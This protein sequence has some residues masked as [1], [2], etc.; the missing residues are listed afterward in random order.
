MWCWPSSSAHPHVLD[1][2]S[3]DDALAHR[4]LDPLL[5]RGDEAAGD[6]A[7][8]DR[9]HELEPGTRLGGRDLDVAVAE[10]AAAAGLLLVAAV[11]L[12]GLSDRL[13]VRHP[14]RMQLDL[15]PEAALHP[16]DDHLDV[17]L[18]E[19]GDDLLAGL[20]IAMDVERGVLLAQAPDRARRLLLVALRLR[21]EG[22]RHHRR[23][24]LQRREAHVRRPWRPARR[25]ARVSFSLATA[26][27]SPGPSSSIGSISL[28]RGAASWPSRS[29]CTRVT[30]STCDSELQHA[31]VHAQQV[32][33]ARVGI[34]RGLEYV[35][36]QVAVRIGLDLDRL[37]LGVESPGSRRAS[38]ARADPRPAPRAGRWC[39]G[40]S[41]RRR[42]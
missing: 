21:L 15:G 37:A 20:R 6:H 35:G 8:L 30:L 4:L 19:A 10:L 12:G 24:Q 5:H 38:P 9:V 27:M 40:S 28:P 22:E 41:S 42:R 17:D 29:F 31:G 14:R 23:R 16:I 26:P 1:R 39:P 33:P 25:P 3:G 2:V 34:G 13:Q 11:R 18:G 32:D 36:D 7:A